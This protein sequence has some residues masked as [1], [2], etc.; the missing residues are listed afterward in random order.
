MLS[1]L[2][3]VNTHG[4][5]IPCFSTKQKASATVALTSAVV[6][7]ILVS[8]ALLK[9]KGVGAIATLTPGV[10]LLGGSALSFLYLVALS[11][12]KNKKPV[13]QIN[14]VK[15]E[16]KA[17]TKSEVKSKAKLKEQPT[18]APKAKPSGP[19]LPKAPMVKKEKA[20]KEP[21]LLPKKPA[22]PSNTLNES[23]ESPLVLYY[24]A[25]NDKVDEQGEVL[26][27]NGKE[28][29]V[30]IG[31]EQKVEKITQEIEYEKAI[32]GYTLQSSVRLSAAISQYPIREQVDFIPFRKFKY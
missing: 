13:P 19:T 10:L 1:C 22:S 3:R 23:P 32:T 28:K 14:R 20:I 9:L 21:T 4:S 5:A 24:M 7:S 6:G 17:E 26:E 25:L 12:E 27:A 15:R 30:V 2:S 18:I 8:I 16:K 11:C 29:A 31:D